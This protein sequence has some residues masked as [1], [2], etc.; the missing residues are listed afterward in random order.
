MSSD[1]GQR[2]VNLRGPGTSLL[3][4]GVGLIVGGVSQV[5][6]QKPVENIYGYTLSGSQTWYVV[7]FILLALGALSVLVGL[8]LLSMAGP[9]GDRRPVRRTTGTANGKTLGELFHR[10]RT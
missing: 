7:G 8:V 10:K 5:V 9:D 4:A 3:L 1:S 2:Q 6:S